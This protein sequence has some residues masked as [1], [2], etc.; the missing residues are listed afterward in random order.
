MLDKMAYECKVSPPTQVAA[1]IAPR[2]G[3]LLAVVQP[4]AAHANRRYHF[5]IDDYIFASLVLYLD[6]INI[7]LNILHL[8][9]GGRD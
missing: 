5:E 2:L 8:L 6:I 3:P 4:N 7:F 1:K 9:G